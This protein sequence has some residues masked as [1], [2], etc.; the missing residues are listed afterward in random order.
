MFPS[1]SAVW[2]NCNIL[3]IVFQFTCCVP[4]PSDSFSLH[5]QLFG[6]IVIFWQLFSS[7]L[8]VCEVEKM[9]NID[10]SCLEKVRVRLGL[11]GIVLICWLL[12]SSLLAAFEVEKTTDIDVSCLDSDSV[13]Q[14]LLF[15][16]RS[17]SVVLFFSVFYCYMVTLP[18][19][20]LTCTLCTVVPVTCGLWNIQVHSVFKWS[21]WQCK[22]GY[23][24]ISQEN[25]QITT[26][27]PEKKHV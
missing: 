18:C 17:S 13:H 26:D 11:C 21:Q 27:L 25:Q 12:F 24:C 23:Q 5:C 14:L 19:W 15:I 8:A 2:H 4:S 16:A 3:T 1:L 9:T 6:V 22:Y 7:L 10:V 20:I